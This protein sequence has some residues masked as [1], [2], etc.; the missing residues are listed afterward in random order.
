MENSWKD[1][2]ELQMIYIL[3]KLQH[4]MITKYWEE[5]QL[6]SWENS[7]C[8]LYVHKMRYEFPTNYKAPKNLNWTKP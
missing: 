6:T 7:Q 8:K 2:C 5:N 3:I 1:M 4:E